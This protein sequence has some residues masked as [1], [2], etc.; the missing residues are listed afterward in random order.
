MNKSELRVTVL[1][2]AQRALLGMIHPSIRAISIG[3]TENTLTIIYY[4]DRVPIDEDY[5]NISVVVSE[6]MADIDF[7]K[8]EEKCVFTKKP[9]STLENVSDW[10]YIRQES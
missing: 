5:E 4:L 8:I 7:S 1:I 2:S 9:L 6:I 10:V 3:F